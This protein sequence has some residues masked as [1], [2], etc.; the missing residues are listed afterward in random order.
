M[1]KRVSKMFPD[2]PTHSFERGAH[3]LLVEKAAAGLLDILPIPLLL[4]HS[5]SYRTIQTRR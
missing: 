2:L 1:K 4:K 5:G 3:A